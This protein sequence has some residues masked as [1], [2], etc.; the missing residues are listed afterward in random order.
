ME[1]VGVDVLMILKVKKQK[2]INNLALLLLVLLLFSISFYQIF[3]N[4]LFRYLI[5]LILILFSL[6]IKFFRLNKNGYLDYKIIIPWTIFI[7]VILISCVYN[8]GSLMP[9]IEYISILILYFFLLQYIIF[10]E[11]I[12]FKSLILNGNLILIYSVFINPLLGSP[13]SGFYRNTNTFGLQLCASFIA[14]TF[15]LMNRNNIIIKIFL[16][17]NDFVFLYFIYLSKSRSSL[18]ICVFC[19]FALLLFFI[20]GIGISR[21]KFIFTFLFL[22]IIFGLLILYFDEV[23]EFIYNI[24]FKYDTSSYDISSGRINKQAEALKYLTFIGNNEIA[25]HSF[26]DFLLTGQL[27]GYVAMIMHFVNCLN[28]LILGIRYYL[29]NKN[30]ESLFYLVIIISFFFLSFFEEIMGAFGLPLV[31]TMFISV[32]RIMFKQQSYY[33]N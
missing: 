4:L 32:G 30:Y 29:Q 12:I 2:I 27:Y 16:L 13:Y 19:I 31:V 25:I 20:R 18:L 7:L 6:Y 3:G 24:I 10:D 22:T 28:F 8:E 11:T 23:Y 26:N 21:K 33:Y 14:C 5:V 9:I 15:F 17:L 1:I